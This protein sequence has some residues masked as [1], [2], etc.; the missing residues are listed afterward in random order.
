M[1]RQSFPLTHCHF[2]IVTFSL[3]RAVLRLQE[4]GLS[5]AA[6]G[7]SCLLPAAAGHGRKP[8]P[9]RDWA[10]PPYGLCRQRGFP[11]NLWVPD[12]WLR[13][14][15]AVHKHHQPLHTHTH[16][17][18]RTHTHTHACTSLGGRPSLA[19]EKGKGRHHVWESYQPGAPIRAAN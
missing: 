4:P 19:E 14:G 8:G 13:G 7:W 10:P 17:H 1:K 5:E 6:G 12:P 2:C 18:T 3:P 9:S 16:T 15:E 11:N